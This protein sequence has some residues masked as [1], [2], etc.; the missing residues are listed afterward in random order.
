[1]V[2]V[3]TIVRGRRTHLIRLVEGL[4]CQ[5][6]PPDELVI[7]Y[8]GHDPHD[9]LPD[10]SFPIVTA[11]MPGEELPLA[12]ARNRAAEMAHGDV[13][14]FL[15]VDCIPAPGL[16]AR[17]AAA[18]KAEAV[19]YLSEVLYQ[20]PMSANDI[21]DYDRMNAIGVRHPAK[22][23]LEENTVRV[24]PDYGQLW[25]LA[26]G[27]RD[28]SWKKAGGMDERF[29]GYGG[30]ETDFAFRLERESIKLYWLGGARAYHQHHHVHIPPYQH[31]PAIIRNARQ[32]H[33]NWGR[34]CMEYW[35]D[36]FAS[37]GLIDWNAEK[38]TVL[39]PPTTDEIESSRQPAAILFS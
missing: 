13:L 2:S 39:R 19:V 9:G 4:N 32:F 16:V 18:C 15:D 27:C 37:A 23:A 1:M 7:C 34:F 24:E 14:I 26:F 8:M 29:Y 35:L 17:Y 21:L 31:F 33:E 11:H 5:T 20:P 28:S 22:P 12:A 30:E 3:C 6:R 38:I 25:G 36:Q 10:T